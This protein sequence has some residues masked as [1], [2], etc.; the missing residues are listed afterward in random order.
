MN[1]AMNAAAAVSGLL[2]L[3]I[4]ITQATQNYIA[5]IS[6]LSHT[7]SSY[8]EELV[9]LKKT[10]SDIQDAILFHST[11]KSVLE[12]ELIQHLPV[13]MLGECQSDLEQL[14]DLLQS[15]QG[16]TSVAILKRL[17]WPLRDGETTKWVGILSRCRQQVQSS[18]ISSGL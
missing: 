11:A 12:V 5:N 2:S 3:T 15:G 17:T 6:T 9:C 13:A 14:Y 7:V 1:A 16:N 18:F 8:L 4:Q 10:L